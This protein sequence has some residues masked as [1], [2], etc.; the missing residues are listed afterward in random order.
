[1]SYSNCLS[2]FPSLDYFK[3]LKELM[4]NSIEDKSVGRL[5]SSVASLELLVHSH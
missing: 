2:A 5:G 4:Q 3:T 1:L